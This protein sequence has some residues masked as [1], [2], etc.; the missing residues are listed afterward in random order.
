LAPSA[1][2]ADVLVVLVGTALLALFAWCWAGRSRGARWWATRR[3]G[4]QL[5]LGVVPGLGLIVVSGGVLTLAG[6]AAALPLTPL[7]LVG[8]V[9]ELAG[10]FDL[11]PRRWGPAWYRGRARSG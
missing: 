7:F 1:T 5:V 11:L 4:P 9:L 6:T 2:L 3:F 8:A 10:I